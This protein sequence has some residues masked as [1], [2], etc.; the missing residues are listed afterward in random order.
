V[1]L[2]L[3]SAI[4]AMAGALGHRTRLLPLGPALLM[5][6]AGLAGCAV[7]ILLNLSRIALSAWRHQPLNL[8][9]TLA[10]LA[11]ALAV[12]AVPASLVLANR[13]NAASLPPIHDI[14]TDTDDPPVFVDVL[15]LRAEAPNPA[16]HGGP[17]IAEQQHRAYPDL[18]PL[19]LDAAPAQAFDR[20]REAVADMGW[21]LVAADQAAGRIEA[22]DTTFWFGFEDDV[23]IRLRPEGDGTRV[24]VRSVSRAGGGDLG[25]NARRIREFLALLTP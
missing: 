24:D 12:I 10:A 13:K 16:D 19:V 25:T 14:S 21:T 11:I 17:A 6:A 20:A 23:V 18:A 4:L 2:A 8:G 9:G 5:A 3:L 15:P 22:T 1:K 7:A